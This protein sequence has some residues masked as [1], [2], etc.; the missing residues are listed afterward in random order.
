MVLVPTQASSRGPGVQLG[1]QVDMAVGGFFFSR[2]NCQTRT[3][4]VQR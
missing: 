1:R 3:L 2:K 4:K